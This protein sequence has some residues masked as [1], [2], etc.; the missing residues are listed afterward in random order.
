MQAVT[1]KG[2]NMPPT[3]P[4][5][6]ETPI[7]GQAQDIEH[8]RLLSLFHYIVG[9]LGFLCGSFPLLH[10]VLGLVMYFSPETMNDGH[11]EPPPKFIGL[12]FAAFGTAFVLFAWVL[13]AFI[14]LSGRYLEQRRKWKISLMVG[15]VQCLMFPFGTVL[16][17]FTL[18][19]LLRPS[20]KQLYGQEA[21]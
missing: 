20:V 8:L 3:P 13:S 2:F 18:V 21:G 19:I 10:V 12:I 17:V 4:S 11:G 6:P 15:A 16:G 9:A 7:P 1:N 14:I 5:P